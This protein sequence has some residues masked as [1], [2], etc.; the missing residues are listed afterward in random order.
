MKFV[1]WGTQWLNPTRIFIL[2]KEVMLALPLYQ[3]YDLL[4]L[5][6]TVKHISMKIRR[7]L[8]KVGKLNQKKFHLM[9]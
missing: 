8:W 7:F 1:Q 2:I 9:D 5:K 3:C 4:A 6:G